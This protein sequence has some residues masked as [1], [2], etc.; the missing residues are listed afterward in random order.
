[1]FECGQGYPE[2][3]ADRGRNG[4]KTHETTGRCA[5]IYLHTSSTRQTMRENGV[6]NIQIKRKSLA[7]FVW[8]RVKSQ[9]TL[10]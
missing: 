7:S 6:L 4:K 2:F 9:I 8:T 5:S 1:M 10:L 3:I